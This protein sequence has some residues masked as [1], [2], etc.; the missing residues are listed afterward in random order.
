[1]LKFFIVLNLFQYLLR[2][3]DI[4]YDPKHRKGLV[5]HKLAYRQYG[6][7]DRIEDELQNLTISEQVEDENNTNTLDPNEELELLLYFRTCIVNR[8]KEILKIKLKQTIELRE[9]LI[10]KKDTVFYQSFPFYFVSPDLVIYFSLFIE[11][12]FNCEY[13]FFAFN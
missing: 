1:M 5:Y 4:L 10:K 9:T 6:K 11:K 7:K 13:C 2:F 8:D 12:N 3:Q